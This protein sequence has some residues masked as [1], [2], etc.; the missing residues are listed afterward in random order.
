MLRGI[1]SIFP[2]AFL[3]RFLVADVAFQESDLVTFWVIEIN[4]VNPAD[5]GIAVRQQI[6]HQ[7]DAEKTADAGNID[8]HGE[9]ILEGHHAG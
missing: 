9:S 2:H 3:E 5:V 7:V 8:F 6:A 1:D 4:Q